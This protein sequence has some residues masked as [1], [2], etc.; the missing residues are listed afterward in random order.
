MEAELIL[1]PLAAL[2]HASRTHFAPFLS[3]PSEFVLI[4]LR[5]FDREKT[6]LWAVEVFSYFCNCFD[7]SPFATVWLEML[8]SAM[9][10]PAVRI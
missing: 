4:G 9:A 5:A 7:L 6:V 8:S 2:A 1:L 10:E 3:Q